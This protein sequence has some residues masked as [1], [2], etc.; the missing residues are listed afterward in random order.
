MPDIALCLEALS[1]VSGCNVIQATE[2]GQPLTPQDFVTIVALKEFYT[3]EGFKE[4][5]FPNLGSLSVSDM[6]KE[7]PLS[8]TEGE[9]ASADEGSRPTVCIKTQDFFDPQYDYNFTNIKDG[10]AKFTRGN[11]KYL[12][13][14]G[15]N[16]V[17][18]KVLKRYQDGDG[19]LGTGSNAWPVSYHGPAMDGSH[20]VIWTLDQDTAEEVVAEGGS[21]SNT[22]RGRGVYSTSDVAIAERFSKSFRSKV[23][24]KM[25]KV[26]LQNRIKPEK[27]Q[28]CRR[29]NI[30]LV[31]VP[32]DSNILQ[33]KAIVEASLRP[34]GL[35]LKQV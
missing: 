19:W 35:L 29:E 18:L 20:G 30:W 12:R 15:W 7:T 16:R 14:C 2:G 11:E 9:T 8:L 10:D 17:A 28:K 5:E 34:Y 13:P 27:R 26:V 31:Y 6:N 21:G 23:D 4:L 33:E 22:T 3:Q 32:E 1:A 25:Y 24:G